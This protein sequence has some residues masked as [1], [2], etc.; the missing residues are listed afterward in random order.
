[1]TGGLFLLLMLVSI[2]FLTVTYISS[3][4]VVKNDGQK[5]QEQSGVIGNLVAETRLELLKQ[6]IDLISEDRNFNTLGTMA[7]S[8]KR[9]SYL[10]S[11]YYSQRHGT[12]DLVA[13]ISIDGTFLAELSTE[14]DEIGIIKDEIR[15]HLEDPASLY[16]TSQQGTDQ[17]SEKVLFFYKRDIINS[18]TGDMEG[19]LVGGLF[20]NSNRK[21]LA[22]IKKKTMAELVALTWNGK[23]LS[24]VGNVPSDLATDN[25]ASLMDA[26]QNT[27]S[28]LK[29]FASGLFNE[30]F[31]GSGLSIITGYPASSEQTLMR[32]LVLSS[33]LAV[34]LALILSTLAALI[35][36]LL[37]L[38]PLKDLI[39]YARQVEAKDVNIKVP[40]SSITEFNEVGYNLESVFAA[41]QESETRFGDIVSITTDSVWET[42]INDRFTFMSRD[43][44]A[45]N[46]DDQKDAIGKKRWEIQGVDQT[47]GNWEAHWKNLTEREPFQ[48]FIYRR[49]DN[50]G[51]Y[52]Y[53]S[54]SGRPRY[55]VH[56]EYCGYR[57]AASDISSEIVAQEEAE[58]MKEML[59]QAKKMEVVGQLT[60]GVAHDFNNLLSVVMGNMELIDESGQLDKIQTKHLADALKGAERGAA[61]THQLLA[62]SRQQT[63]H[64]KPVQLYN[65]IWDM[66]DKFT[67]LLGETITI[68]NKMRDNWSVLVDAKELEN[69]LLNLAANAK[70]A[71]PSGGELIV[72][73]FDIHLD[74]EYVETVQDLKKGDYVCLVMTDTGEGIADEIRDNILEPFFTTKEVGKGS[75]L[76]LSMVFGFLKQSGGHISIYSEI[77][78]GTSVQLYLPRTFIAK[79]QEQSSLPAQLHY[80]NGELVLVVEDNVQ[81][82]KLVVTQLK[83]LRYK[84]MECEDGPTALSVLESE[85]ID[86]LLSDVALPLGLNGVDIANFAQDQYPDMPKLLMSGFTGEAIRNREEL[87]ENIEILY[88]PFTKARLSEAIYHAIKQRLKPEASVS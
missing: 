13:L 61:L 18:F 40:E 37:I 22:E 77:G 76:G 23:I 34:I 75:G 73:C 25:L 51:R 26:L 79:E 70:D 16:W 8:K 14:V 11:A 68:K 59:I 86:I 56:G 1:M 81:V 80:G 62:Y 38:K 27:D 72:E 74:H 64:P 55:D 41:F 44:T 48:K 24:S 7:G 12:V 3:H 82:R 66:T 50:E 45:P 29:Y 6:T 35:G 30:Q 28:S 60:G 53:W 32:L 84:T 9:V 19:F 88:K 67:Q 58:K 46:D 36:R 4:L 49:K 10:N 57:G 21:L 5:L 54:V 83:S 39:A 47:F 69:A 15:S 65:I 17:Q 52:T 43:L 78:Q 87:P 2:A 33:S 20:L 31:P 71:M 63:L 85:P 42:D